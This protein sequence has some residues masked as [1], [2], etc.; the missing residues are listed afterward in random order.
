MNLGIVRKVIFMN[1]SRKAFDNLVTRGENSKVYTEHACFLYV[2]FINQDGKLES[3]FFKNEYYYK[4]GEIVEL[5]KQGA[6]FTIKGKLSLEE[7]K[8][9]IDTLKLLLDKETQMLMEERALIKEQFGELEAEIYDY[10][11]E[12]VINV[13]KTV[14]DPNIIKGFRANLIALAQSLMANQSELPRE[15]Y[16]GYYLLLMHLTNNFEQIN[17][18][19]SLCGE[20]R[21]DVKLVRDLYNIVRRTRGVSSSWFS[22]PIVEGIDSFEGIYGLPE[23]DNFEKKHGTD[24]YLENKYGSR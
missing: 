12:N 18:Q 6:N 2:D 10:E 7:L 4:D 22:Q 9:Q 14:I 13:L 24:K 8:S 15:Q 5:D 1:A 3:V 11:R 19:L 16:E 17:R 21:I 20:E 23:N